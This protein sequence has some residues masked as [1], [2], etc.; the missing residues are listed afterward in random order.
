MFSR[1]GKGLYGNYVMNAYGSNQHRLQGNP[2]TVIESWSQD[3]RLFAG[4]RSYG[5][6]NNRFLSLV[7]NADGTGERRL[8]SG[9]D[10]ALID[11]RMRLDDWFFEAD[12]PPHRMLKASVWRGVYSE[13][14]LHCSDW[15]VDVAAA[16]A[17]FCACCAAAG[18]SAA[19]ASA[20]PIESSDRV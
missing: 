13:R 10:H 16:A 2:G 1:D 11:G 5:Q 9:G 7:L 8:L 19:T 17:E 18:K 15:A 3:G 6:Y 14:R 12:V 4:W 20:M